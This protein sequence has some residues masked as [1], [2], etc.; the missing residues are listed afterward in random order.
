MSE[1]HETNLWLSSEKRSGGKFAVSLGL[2]SEQ[3]APKVAREVNPH[4]PE[5]RKAFVDEVRV[6]LPGL[7]GEMSKVEEYLLS[8]AVPRKKANPK[9]ATTSTASGWLPDRLTQQVNALR[10]VEK[11]NGAARFNKDRGNWMVHRESEGR[12]VNDDT[13]AVNRAAKRVAK[14]T[15]A[16]VSNPPLGIDPKVAFR[17]AIDSEKASGISAMMTLAQTETGISIVSADL[18]RDAYMLNCQNGAVDFRTGTLRPHSR[19]ELFSKLAPVNCDPAAKC[20]VWDAFMW[21]IMA[22]KEHMIRYLQ[23]IAGLCGTG[24]IDVQEL[25]IFF[26]GGANG[27][28]VFIDTTIGMYGDYA[29]IAPD[30]LLTTRTHGQEHPTEIAGL[31]GKRLV[32]ASETEEG[33]KL[34]VQLVK[35]LTGDAE[36]TGRYMR[37]DF[38]TFP[39]THKLI[40]VTNNRPCIRETTNAVWRRVRLIPF[41]VTIPPEE[42]DPLLLSKLKAEWSGILNWCV[43]GFL[44]FQANGMQT[45]A[46]V[47][48]A[49][50]EYQTEQDTLAEYIGERCVRG[51]SSYVSRNEIFADYALWAKT[52]GDP[53]PDRNGFYDRL[54]RVG[55]IEEGSK[56]LGGRVTRIFT[57]IGLANLGSQYQ[58]AQEAAAHGV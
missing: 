41:T 48:V 14:E 27:K 43:A 46:E 7:N 18:D 28:S 9:P 57:G 53:N 11:L 54:R 42:R 55:G 40:L 33:A 39:R 24:N 44:D 50:E 36:I 51:D 23:R 34:R 16:F 58:Q 2:G 26:G 22:G 15:W 37:Q 38:F 20:P 45:P 10:L 47:T 8:L 21:R 19:G 5:D 31:C 56:R 30:S 17:H 1:S 6:A 25:F 52:I 3:N 35:R 29:G 49:T 12:M 13:G 32:A 4:H